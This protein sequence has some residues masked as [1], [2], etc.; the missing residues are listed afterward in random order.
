M[1]ST[2]ATRESRSTQP[3]EAAN[4]PNAL[5]RVDTVLALTGMG[6][7]KLYALTKQGKFPAPTKREPRFTRWK[8]G[9][10]TTW[11]QAQ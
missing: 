9:D 11:L 2:S 6:R 4:H 7:S 5:L 3:L 8:A 1:N 10:V